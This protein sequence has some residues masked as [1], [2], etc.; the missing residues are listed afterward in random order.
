MTK[1]DAFTVLDSEFKLVR[2]V[3]PDRLNKRDWKT[4]Q[5]IHAQLKEQLDFPYKSYQ[6]DKLD[7]SERWAVYVLYPKSVTPIVLTVENT[8]MDS[9]TVSFGEPELHL[10]LKLLQVQY[11]RGEEHGKFIGRDACFIYA[12]RDGKSAHIC[13]EINLKGDLGNRDTDATQLFKVIGSAHKFV[14]PKKPLEAGK[15]YLNAYYGISNMSDGI[16]FFRQLKPSQVIE[17]SKTSQVYE[18]RTFEGRR[19]TLDYY[20]LD[21][22]ERSRGYLLNAFIAG[23]AAFLGKYGFVV[24]PV[25]RQF[26]KFDPTPEITEFELP[27]DMLE[28]VNIYDMRLNQHIPIERYRTLFQSMFPQVRFEVLQQ[29]TSNLKVA[30][31]YIMDYEPEAF[32]EEMPLHGQNDPYQSLYEQYP[33]IPKQGLNVNPNE[34]KRAEDYDKTERAY[35]DYDRLNADDKGIRQAITVSM[36]QLFLK[37]LIMGSRAI[38]DRLPITDVPFA[39][40]RKV[41]QQRVSYET[42]LNFENG[43]AQFLDL[44]DPEQREAFNQ[45]LESWGVS[46]DKNYQMLA[47]KRG[48]KEGDDPLTR[49]DL[50]IGPGL[51]AEIEDLN[52]RVLYEFDEITQRQEKR[53]NPFP[54]HDFKLA[55]RYDD[56]RTSAMLSRSELLKH[57]LI[58]AEGNGLRSGQTKK[59]TQS[60]ELITQL[61][62]YDA[63]LDEIRQQYPERTVQELCEDEHWMPRI[64]QIFGRQPDEQGKYQSRFL[65]DLYK[66]IDM[67]PSDREGELTPTYQGIWSDNQH[68]FIV[69]DVY[70]LK[71]TGQARAH[72]IRQFVIYQGAAQ[73]D[74]HTM[75]DATSVKFV[76]LNQFTVYPYFFHLLDVFIENVLQYQIV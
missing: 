21:D 30:V 38:Q 42:A 52:E 68:R 56:V 27:L 69:G 63:L 61:R 9:R 1:P 24:Q 66:R 20:S 23:F 36:N 3:I 58:D 34:L 28:V 15:Q 44:R 5:R 8:E 50:V 12:K 53:R 64:A 55:E 11:F 37:D 59:Q 48:K 73:F 62:D 7:G 19:T 70:S 6:Y 22:V 13:M 17:F 2:Y 40:V 29:L 39:F 76:R 45:R 35:L 33:Q 57:G 16:V 26:T 10:L 60:L 31:L 54:I 4:F 14:I 32:D 41:T 49:Y 71:L 74:S 25:E 72:L 75:L 51:F 65:R 67:F 47:Q 46:W 18:Q 43:I